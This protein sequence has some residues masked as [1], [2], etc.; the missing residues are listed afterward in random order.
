MRI[1]GSMHTV[2]MNVC[3]G[4]LRNL[5]FGWHLA[6]WLKHTDDYFHLTLCVKFQIAACRMNIYKCVLCQGATA[7]QHLSVNPKLPF[8]AMFLQ[9]QT[10]FIWSQML[11][12]ITQ[13]VMHTHFHI[14][15]NR[16]I[17]LGW[18]FHVVWL[19]AMPI[20]INTYMHN[21]S[22]LKTC[23]WLFS[24]SSNGDPRTLCFA[25]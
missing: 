12:A 17:S 10:R 4:E 20:L 16:H 1:S 23:A 25:A 11:R 19:V 5:T 8:K 3:T 13:T 14:L 22:S 24:L 15:S 2:G 6:V 21:I 18:N 9:I 7:S